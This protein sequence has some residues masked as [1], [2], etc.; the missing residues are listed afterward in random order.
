[1]SMV[2]HLSPGWR[3]LRFAVM[4]VLL[5]RCADIGMALHCIFILLCTPSLVPHVDC[6]IGREL[7]RNSTEAKWKCRTTSQ[8]TRC[9][10]KLRTRASASFL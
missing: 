9:A 2:A 7:E 6:I 5:V 10:G 8:H 3:L 4:V 1:M